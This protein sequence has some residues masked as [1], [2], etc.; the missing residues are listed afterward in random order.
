M[1]F[2]EKKGI[3]GIIAFVVA[4]MSL[5]VSFVSDF[6]TEIFPRLGVGLAIL[7]VVMIL[8]GLFIPKKNWMSYVL[9]G[10]SG[11][12]L[13]V[14]LVQTAGEVGW[15]TGQWWYDNWPL[16]AGAVFVLVIIAVIVGASKS[17]SEDHMDTPIMKA[18]FGSSGKKE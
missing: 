14:V 18:L 15:S 13:V 1:T 10:I 8:I 16:V 5:Q 6:F 2:E 12:I 4:L 17:E 9:L 3:N 11:I 7:L